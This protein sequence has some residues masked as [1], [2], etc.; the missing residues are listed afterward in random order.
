MTVPEAKL[1]EIVGK[2][3][4]A[5]EGLLD[6]KPC[7][8][9]PKE[10]H[11]MLELWSQCAHCGDQSAHAAVC[12]ACYVRTYTKLKIEYLKGVRRACPKCKNVADPD[13][14]IQQRDL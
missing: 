2:V 7:A 10:G 4:I 12:H 8:L 13:T 9:A 5:C 1:V 14:F 6:G 11:A 3:D